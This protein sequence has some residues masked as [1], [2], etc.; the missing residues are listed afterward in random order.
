MAPARAVR[1]LRIGIITD[2]LQER[3]VDGEVRIANGGVGVYI[4]QLI[5]HLLLIDPVNQYFLIR[6]GA[7]IA[8]HLW[9]G[10]P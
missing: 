6:F 3:M 7:G 8:R 5:R 10:G 9:R 2:G 1:P 4:Y